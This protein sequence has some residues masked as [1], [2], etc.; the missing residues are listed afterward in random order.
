[1]CSYVLEEMLSLCMYRQCSWDCV[2]SLQKCQL[3]LDW[4]SWENTAVGFLL[5]FP[6]KILYAAVNYQPFRTLLLLI[7]ASVTTVCVCVCVC[8][9]VRARMCVCV[10]YVCMCFICVCVCMCF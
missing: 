1:M 2:L 7:E 6:V 8:A 4:L 10:V 5:W 3:Q 9:C